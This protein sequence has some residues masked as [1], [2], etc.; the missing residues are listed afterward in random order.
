MFARHIS[1]MQNNN[2]KNS[3]FLEI[4]DKYKSVIAK[5]CSIYASPTVDFD[6]LYQETVINLWNGFDSFR[7][8]A[9]ISTW[10]YRAA[11]NTCI[12]WTRRNKKHSNN[13][14]LEADL[15]IIDDESSKLADYK[16]LQFLI[17]KLNPIEKAIIS[18][19]LD[20]KSYDE[21][22]CITGI[23]HNNVAVKLHRIKEKMSKMYQQ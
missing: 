6:D 9:K 16:Q 7:G 5:V 15:A 1:V 19:W 17:S 21:I 14:S 13:V 8:E 10:I 20:E 3:Q 4:L 12:T 2:D 23:S 18:L 11:I 22:S